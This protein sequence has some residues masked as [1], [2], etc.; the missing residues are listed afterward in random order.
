MAFSEGRAP[1]R[2]TVRAYQV[3]FGDCFLLS[4]HYEAADNRHIL[5]DFGSTEK[6][7]GAPQRSEMMRRIAEDIFDR[8]GS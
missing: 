5:I 1:H 3:G 7:E 8:C 6:P 2:I 4:F